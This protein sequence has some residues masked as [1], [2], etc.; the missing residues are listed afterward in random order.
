MKFP[1]EIRTWEDKLTK[2]VDLYT[3]NVEGGSGENGTVR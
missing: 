3:T 1:R 2:K